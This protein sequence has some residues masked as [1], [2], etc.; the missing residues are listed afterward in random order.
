MEQDIRIFEKINKAI[1]NLQEFEN[2]QAE[3]IKL[4]N[5]GYAYLFAKNIQ[6]YAPNAPLNV[7]ALQQIVNQE[8]T[9]LLLKVDFA[10]FIKG[11]DRTAVVELCKKYKNV[12]HYN[13]LAKVM[14]ESEK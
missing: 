13:H 5:A 10:T 1:S 2:L 9:P 12:P 6:Q 11:A 14:E 4:N 7:K 3:I 8:G